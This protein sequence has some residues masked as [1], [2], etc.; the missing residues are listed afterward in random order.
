[1]AFTLYMMAFSLRTWRRNGV[2]CDELLFLPGNTLLVQNNNNAANEGDV[3][4]GGVSEQEL[5]M[6]RNRSA[7]TATNNSLSSLQEFVQ[8][9]SWDDDDENDHNDDDDTTAAEQA[10]LRSNNS[11]RNNTFRENH[12][13]ITRI[14]S[15][16]F[17]RTSS[18]NTSTPNAA[19]YAPSG[20]SVVGAA[21]DMSMPTLFNFHLF[22]E[23]YQHFLEGNGPEFTA[24][25]LPMIFLSVLIIRTVVPPGRRG[26]FWTTLSYTV[27]APWQV[28]QLRD[29][30][31]GDVLTSLVRPFQDVVFALAY[32]VTVL[33]GSLSGRYGLLESG[34]RLEH[35]R[36]LHA[37]ILPS[38][39]LLPLWWR[40]L[41]CLRQAYDE[42]QRWPALGNAWKYLTAGWI[43]LY[44]MTHPERGWEY[45]TVFGCGVVYQLW[46][47]VVMDWQLFVVG[48]DHAVETT[49]CCCSRRIIS[50]V[51]PNSYVLLGL[52]R[53]VLQPVRDV[54]WYCWSRLPRQI[55]LRSRRLYKQDSLYWRILVYNTLFRW[56]WMLSYIPNNPFMDTHNYLGVV[57]PMVEILRRTLWGFLW[58]EVQTIRMTQDQE[59][60]VEDV[61]ESNDSVDQ[62]KQHDR[63]FPAV[64]TEC[65]GLDASTRDRLYI[66]EL[67]LWAVAFVGFGLWVT[68]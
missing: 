30:M 11:T 64:D 47:D 29:D 14:G 62:S 44:G 10:P 4:G 2:A 20:P 51:R 34:S 52:Q 42:Q 25:I 13:R 35:N 37:V 26:R 60:E 5:P 46:W 12:P 50:S 68:T 6:I 61:S 3:A 33:Y 22:I 59:D 7:S 58:L 41:Q 65:C 1:L 24:K 45:W 31:V 53:H 36:L 55:S 28:W 32:Y 57:L 21:L 43:V 56:V 8:A 23:A 27:T 16:F 40:F 67:T 66:V 39:S 9:S 48:R 19:A 49:D 18:S 63:W 17:F 15:F 38:C 54:V